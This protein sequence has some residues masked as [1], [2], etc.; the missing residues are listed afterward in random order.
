MATKKKTQKS[1]KKPKLE[2]VEGG[3][4]GLQQIAQQLKLKVPTLAVIPDLSKMDFR[5]KI[6]ALETASKQIQEGV[7]GAVTFLRS[8]ARQVAQYKD[9]RVAMK[10][11]A[12]ETAS[13]KVKMEEYLDEVLNLEDKIL[14]AVATIAYIK[15]KLSGEFQ[16]LEEAREALADLVDEGILLQTPSEGPERGP[17]S[18]GYQSYKV[19]DDL[20]VE[21]ADLAEISQVIEAFSQTLKGLTKI[22]RT[23]QKGEAQQQADITF[24]EALE[25]KAGKCL[26][27]VPAE[28]VLDRDGKVVLNEDGT[29]KWR[30]GGALLVEFVRGEIQPVS[31]IGACEKAVQGM[32]ELGITL[33]VNTLDWEKP[34]G[35]DPDAFR[36]LKSG[37]MRDRGLDH[38]AAVSFVKKTQ[39][40]WHIIQ[41][42]MKNL[43]GKQERD[44]LKDEWRKEAEVSLASVYGL[45]G[46]FHQ[47]VVLFE[48]KNQVF[49]PREDNQT[50]NDVFFLGRTIQ[51]DQIC[52][53]AIGEV[54]P[55]LEDLLGGFVGKTY[56]I[57]NNFSH[58]PPRLRDIFKRIGDQVRH[59]H[60]ISETTEAEV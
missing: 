16:T 47:G 48:L 59:D 29:P 60:P 27:D 14:L 51:N 36:R 37:A 39:A 13:D 9:N 12:Q 41:R 38:D 6:A 7:A 53:V 17:I 56:R 42:G 3:L 44:A 24:A 21:Q 33:S 45:N 25:G 55:H 31:G 11:I 34:P 18:I 22:R 4:E 43:K 35:F 28:A 52:A 8:L 19:A 15:A 2:T 10:V 58:C 5:E 32:K 26:I 23:E 20:G 54:P 57:D 1:E 40:L 46:G 49:R 30:G 50:F